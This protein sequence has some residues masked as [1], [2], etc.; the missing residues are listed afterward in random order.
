MAFSRIEHAGGAAITTLSSDIS[1]GDTSLTLVTST[2]W[3]TGG[4][5][6]FYLVIDPGLS[7]EEKILATARS[8][9]SLT[10]LTRGVDG[11]SAS[12]HTAGAVIKHIFTAVE[13]DEA[14]QTA[15]ATLGAVVAKGDWLLG[16]ASQALTKLTV[17]ADDT[18][19]VAAS[20]QT[21]GVLW[22]Q[23]ATANIADNAVTTAKIPDN[24]ITALKINTNVADQ[25]LISGG[26]GV[27]F[28]I[29]DGAIGSTQ[30]TDGGIANVDLADGA[31]TYNK[32]TEFPGCRLGKS[33]DQ[34]IA[35]TTATAIIFG[36]EIRDTQTM[37]SNS[38]NPTRITF[39]T[40][41]VYDVQGCVEF[42]PSATG[43]RRLSIRLNGS[44]TLSNIQVRAVADV[45]TPTIL[46]V[47]L[48]G[49]P[50]AL[51]DYVELVVEHNAGGNLNVSQSGAYSPTFAAT[52][53]SM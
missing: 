49:Y 53:V 15:H 14:N 29:P 44:D 39:N 18:V 3:P 43:Y 45:A 51:N 25:T 2:N 35:D 42:A 11:T 27:A 40:A 23:V 41:A 34:T 30:I 31:V 19:P 28:T 21:T 24:A 20:G 46:N 12:A 50:F 17:G 33:T 7:G 52:W 36:V 37:H 9:N 38:P 10:G 13:A 48:V 4:T 5:G 6:P 32:T 16:S 26:A 1:S 22:Q 47:T 8:T